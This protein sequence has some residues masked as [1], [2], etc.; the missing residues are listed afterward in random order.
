MK[1]NKTAFSAVALAFTTTLFGQQKE[2]DLDPIT[3]TASVAPE[4]ASRTGRNIIIIK[5]EKFAK[6]PVHSV[7]ELLK[8]VPGIEVQQRGPF[9]A[10]S[11]IVLRGGTFQ[12]VLVILDGVR[13]NDAN[14]GHFTSYIPIAPAEI[15]RIE[16]LKGASSAIYG[17]EAVGGVIHI[18]TKS[19]AAKQDVNKQNATVQFT[20]GEYDLFSLNAGGFASNGKTAFSAGVLSNHTDGQLQ[21]GTRGYAG[22][23]TASASLSH[24]F[25]DRLQVALRTAYDDRDFAAQNFYTNFI[26]D[27]AKEQVKSFWNQ[28]QLS[29]KGNKDVIRFSA[30]YK[31]LEDKYSFNK[32]SVPNQNTSKLLQALLTDEWTVS[33]NTIITSGLQ[34]IDKKIASNDRGNHSVKQSAA[35]V[36]LNQQ[37]GDHLFLSPAL[38]IEW[39]ERAGW[40]LVPQV[41]LSY[42]TEKLQL[43][44]SAGK[45]T[46]DA[47]FTERFNNYNKAFVASGRIGNPGLVAER[48]FSYEAGGDYFAGSAVKLSA[49]FFQRYHNNLIDYVTTPY[50]QMPRQVNLSPTGIYALA[51]NISKVTT[52]GV[53]ADIQFSRQLEKGQELT[54]SLGLTWLE[55]RTSNAVPSFYISS[56]AKYLAN[57]N[58]QYSNNVL[59]FSMTGI[60]KERAPQSGSAAIAKVSSDYFVVNAKAQAFVWA[61]KAA[62]F[63]EADNLFNEKYAD[64]LGAQMPGRWLMGGIQI[65]L[66]K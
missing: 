16:V 66:S 15:E 38:R 41:N 62:L 44:G 52:T 64:L 29:Y 46:R 13:L 20:A 14:T 47:D 42:R 49:T 43:R 60:Y 6:L 17:S 56:P 24:Y 61:R 54:G 28:L 57:L 34:F 50:S 21:R 32:A 26:S 9:G 25:T 2:S 55:S 11:D 31:N 18:I 37:A 30:G 48:S 33:A 10:Q 12:Q 39:N 7:D 58:V 65:T 45:T 51:K 8:Y 23:K 22:T 36:V 63:V 40:E 19:F 27:T 53:E 35:F 4:K 3:I 1:I 59:L 5:G